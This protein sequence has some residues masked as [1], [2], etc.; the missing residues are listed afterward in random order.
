M[1]SIVTSPT[2]D[3][4]IAT[5]VTMSTVVTIATIVTI[6]T[7]DAAIASIVRGLLRLFLAFAAGADL[8][9]QDD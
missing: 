6:P 1:A 5:I 2:V 9:A 4:A 7:V 3:A 8:F